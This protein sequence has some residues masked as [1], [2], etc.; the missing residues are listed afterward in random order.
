MYAG[1]NKN[2]NLTQ[3]ASYQPDIDR[4]SPDNACSVSLSLSKGIIFVVYT[5]GKYWLDCSAYHV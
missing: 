2:N 5:L 3:V 4:P 1:K